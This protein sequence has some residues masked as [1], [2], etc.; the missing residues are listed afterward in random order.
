MNQKTD[1]QVRIPIWSNQEREL[2]GQTSEIGSDEVK[3]T[4][5]E[6]CKLDHQINPYDY[7]YCTV[8][9][10]IKVQMKQDFNSETG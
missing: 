8:E 7:S 2:I 1:F 6:P 9:N 5:C 4:N 3:Q 10:T